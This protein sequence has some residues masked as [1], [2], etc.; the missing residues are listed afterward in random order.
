MKHYLLH[1]LGTLPCFVSI[2]V[3]WSEF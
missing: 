3:Y 1:K 2:V